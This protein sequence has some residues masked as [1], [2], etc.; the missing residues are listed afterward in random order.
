MLSMVISTMYTPS[1]RIIVNLSNIPVNL[2]KAVYQ[3]GSIEGRSPFVGGLVV[4]PNFQLPP[5]LGDTGG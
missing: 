1:I 2:A 5:R 4:Y 3:Q